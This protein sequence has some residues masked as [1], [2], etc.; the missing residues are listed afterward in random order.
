ML[1]TMNKQR[2]GKRVLVVVVICLLIIV[3]VTIY[4][5]QSRNAETTNS[6]QKNCTTYNNTVAEQCAE[7]YIGLSLG[8]AVYKA[9]QANL[10]PLGVLIDGESQGF[11]DIARNA[12]IYFEVNN[13]I[14]TKAYFEHDRALH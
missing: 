13:D 5:T 12:P 3:P 8:D 7:D 4:L 1:V 14:V 2:Y 11:T 10:Q 9:N 6:Q